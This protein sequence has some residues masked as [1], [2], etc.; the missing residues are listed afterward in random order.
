MRTP[1]IALLLAATPAAAADR[2]V[3]VSTRAGQGDLYLG[4]PGGP[5][6]RLTRDPAADSVPRCSPDGR[7][8]VFVRGERAAR[9]VWT[10]DLDTMAERR[11]TDND[12]PDFTP[13]WSPDGRWILFTRS[14]GGKDRLARMRPDGTGVE[15]LTANPWHDTK[16]VHA[17]KAQAVVFHSYRHG[18]RN[19]EIYLRDLR[20]GVETRLTDDQ[21]ADYEADLGPGGAIAFSSNRAGGPFQLYAA[22]PDGSKPRQLTT[23]AEDTWGARWSPDGR[24]LFYTGKPSA[25]TIKLIGPRGEISEPWG[26]GGD[27]SQPDWCPAR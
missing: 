24:L 27:N 1:L 21:G 17:P 4:I 3:F 26:A 18:G 22:E 9:E 15:D 10:L 23:T 20:T 8:V 7:R 13:S 16:P 5:V 19:T 11:L 12:T 14:V 25:W 2:M 6:M